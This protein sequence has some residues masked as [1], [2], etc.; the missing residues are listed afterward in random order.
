[1]SEE[2]WEHPCLKCGACCASFRVSF[3]SKEVLHGG[4][5]KVPLAMTENGG[6]SWLSMKGTD[7][8][9]RPA[10]AA[11]E[12]VIGKSVSCQIYL[13]RPSPCRNFLASFEDGRHR[14]RCDEARKKHGLRP[15]GREA[16]KR[17]EKSPVSSV[18]SGDNF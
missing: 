1:M 12:G 10:C 14:P 13:Q 18:L 15:L 9:H 11:L 16:F 5:W 3:H 7:R 2:I 4:L 17:D 6:N 8:K